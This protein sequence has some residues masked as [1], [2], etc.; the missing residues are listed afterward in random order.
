[1]SAKI[2]VIGYIKTFKYLR[3]FVILIS[4]GIKD[5]MSLL[6]SNLFTRWSLKEISANFKTIIELIR[7]LKLFKE[8]DKYKV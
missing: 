2:K 3:R 6:L 8:K 7:K 1:M 5:E 4:I